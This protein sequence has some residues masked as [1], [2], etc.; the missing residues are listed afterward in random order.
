[1]GQH[2]ALLVDD[3]D[4][5]VAELRDQG[6]EVS[7]PSPVGPGRQAFTADPAGNMI[8]LNQPNR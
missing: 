3:L 5:A 8:E 4:A 6:L 7:D 1:M 2:F